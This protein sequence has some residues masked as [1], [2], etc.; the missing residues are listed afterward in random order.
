MSKTLT[1]QGPQKIN[2]ATRRQRNVTPL[3]NALL[4]GL[5]EDAENDRKGGFFV[6]NN[7]YYKDAK[8]SSTAWY[9]GRIIDTIDMDSDNEVRYVIEDEVGII[10]GGQNGVEAKDIKV[11]TEKTTQKYTPPL[12]LPSS[13]FVPNAEVSFSMGAKTFQGIILAR[14]VES[15]VVQVHGMGQTTE[16]V[17]FS[18]LRMYTQKKKVKIYPQKTQE[19]RKQNRWASDQGG[20]VYVCFEFRPKESSQKPQLRGEKLVEYSVGKM[21]GVAEI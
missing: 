3:P 16:N 2:Q 20:S 13:R 11:V 4:K 19:H 17:H 6:G 7:V 5:Q 1:K 10:V 15:F 18:Q 9:F 21:L 12:A 8:R 14:K